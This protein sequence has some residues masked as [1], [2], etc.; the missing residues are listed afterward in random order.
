MA[1]S[2]S[3]LRIAFLDNKQNL[4]R[5]QMCFCCYFWSHPRAQTF[6]CERVFSHSAE[7]TSYDLFLYSSTHLVRSRKAL[8]SHSRRVRRMRGSAMISPLRNFDCPMQA[9][10]SANTPLLSVSVTI[11]F[12]QPFSPPTGLVGTLARRV[13]STKTN[14]SEGGG[15]AKQSKQISSVQT[16]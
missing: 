16:K 10:S 13:F 15:A 14:S 3:Q 1:Q 5:S 8:H 4:F 12:G 6:I 7:L 9:V 11:D 2:Q